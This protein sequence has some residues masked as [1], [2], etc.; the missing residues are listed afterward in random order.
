MEF[1]TQSEVFEDELL[2]ILTTELN[3]DKLLSNLALKIAAS[4][5]TDAC[6]IATCNNSYGIKTGYWSKSPELLTPNISLYLKNI[7]ATKQVISFHLNSE[8]AEDLG[9]ESLAQQLGCNSLLYLHTYYQEQ[10]NGF[11]AL[12]F[13]QSHSWSL[14]TQEKIRKI[15]LLLSLTFAYQQVQQQQKKQA[16]YQSFLINLNREIERTSQMSTLWRLCLTGLGAC[17]KIDQGM[18]VKLK[19][20]DPFFTLSE[21]VKIPEAEVEIIAQWSPEYPRKAIP[22]MFILDS[23]LLLKKAWLNSPNPLILENVTKLIQQETNLFRTHIFPNTIIIPLLTSKIKSTAKEVI[24]GFIILQQR[25]SRSWQNEDIRLVQTVAMQISMA[26]IQSQSLRQVETLVQE[27]TVQLKWSLDMQGKLFTKTR[28]QLEQLKRLDKVKDEF[29]ARLSDELRLPLA[30]MKMAISMLKLT[31]NNEKNQHYLTILERECNKETQL[32][33]DLLTFEQI[34]TSQLEFHYELISINQIV[35]QASHIFTQNWQEKNLT[36][37]IQ[38]DPQ[39]QIYSDRESLLR[40]LNELLH[41]SGKFSVPNSTVSL[42]I[43]AILASSQSL[44]VIKV[45]NLGREITPTEKPQIFDPFYR[46]ED[47]H[48]GSSQGTG[49]GLFLVKSLVELLNGTIVLDSKKTRDKSV[50]VTLFKITLPRLK[51]ASS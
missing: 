9:I 44:I 28:Q 23:S 40:I 42:E 25:E 22:K 1:V 50:F 12:G 31:K 16:Q 24:L 19:Y 34:K 45:S 11:I 43:Q 6:L 3:P 27:R 29:I 46:G 51:E 5:L 30:N 48:Q 18:I 10:V 33:N 32:I 37:A 8:A 21:Q 35:E 36:L 26:M 14:L 13:F 17:L 38:L 7:P 2:E 49:L 4:F 20:L 47:L 39:L 15:G 41:N